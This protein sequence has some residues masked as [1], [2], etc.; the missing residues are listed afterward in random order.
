MQD[1]I[2][3]KNPVKEALK[4]DRKISK[5]FIGKY[6]G[7]DK[8]IDKIISLA[9]E[10]RVPYHW[11]DNYTLQK[12]AKFSQ[13][14]VAI[15]E[16]KSY[17]DYHEFLADAKS[18][19]EPPFILILDSLEDPQNFGAIVRTCDAAGVHG[20]IIPKNRSVSVTPTVGK[21][22]AGA[23][24]HVKVARVANLSSTINDLKEQGLWVVGIDHLG[25]NKMSEVDLKMP[26][27]VVV[28]GENKGIAPLVKTRCDY[29]V[30]I[31][32]RGKIPSLN[33]SVAAALM[34]Y[35]VYRQRLPKKF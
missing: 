6:K 10:K 22:S 21:T 26:I 9:K 20:V 23:I 33:A 32:M 7:V 4:A 16:G 1:V 29:I 14:V 35:E 30:R 15:A 12:Y 3:G 25:S 24:E 2:C 11:A 19:D 13:G 34:L 17:A 5:I 8:N 28:G 31:P 27:A 18:K